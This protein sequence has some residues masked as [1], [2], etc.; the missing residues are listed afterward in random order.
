MDGK[1]RVVALTGGI[2]S[3]KS[4]VAGYLAGNG[5]PVYDSDSSAKALYDR[6]P[7]LVGRL[8]QALGL[9]LRKPD[10]AFD[11]GKLAGA[12]FSSPEA[13]SLVESM[14]LP[15]VRSDFA[16]WRDSQ[17][18]HDWRGYLGLPPFVV[19]E[20]ATVTEK[21]LFGKIYDAAVL[22]TAPLEQRI[23]R[24]CARDKAPAEAVMRRIA[25][26][27]FD[28]SKIDAVI[29]NDSTLELMR[30]RTDIAFKLLSLQIV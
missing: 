20:S 27:K 21:A 19:M 10:G 15:A 4:A 7:A 13:L 24:A 12:I 9:P 29:N 14:V 6:D 1:F 3:G 26:Q 23:A 5:V 11:K 18:L 28:L 17:D 16:A 2:G 22:V 25:V 8:E 30:V